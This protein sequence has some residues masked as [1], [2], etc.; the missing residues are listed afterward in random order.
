MGRARSSG[1]LRLP[2]GIRADAEAITRL[3]DGFSAEHLDEEYAALRH[4]LVGKLARKRPSPLVRG[5]SASWRPPSSTPSA[6]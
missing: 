2:V 4:K 6:G 1:A 5:A 3:T